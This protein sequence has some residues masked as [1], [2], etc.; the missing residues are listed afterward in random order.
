MA[1][2]TINEVHLVGH[3]GKDAETKYTPKGKMLV[4]FSLATGGGQKRDGGG[5]WPTDWHNCTVWG[6]GDVGQRAAHIKK[7]DEVELFGRISYGSYEKDGRKVYTTDIVVT[8]FGGQEEDYNQDAPRQASRP[9]SNVHNQE[10]TDD[11]I[12]F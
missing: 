12:E 1:S 5:N 9:A 8:K 11:D 3:A 10:I 7:G 6:D 2:K 4:K